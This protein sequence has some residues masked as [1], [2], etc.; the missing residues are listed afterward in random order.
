M[1]T[2]KQHYNGVHGIKAGIEYE[3]E[4]S[5]KN[6]RY[7]D[8]N[9]SNKDYMT[10]VIINRTMLDEHSRERLQCIRKETVCKSEQ[11]KN[12]EAEI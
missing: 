1:P 10:N 11:I 4:I 8:D 3:S 5:K 6:V 12:V 7:A 9:L 2:K